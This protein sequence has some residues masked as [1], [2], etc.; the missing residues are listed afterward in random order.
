MG[1][2]MSLRKNIML[3]IEQSSQFLLGQVPGLKRINF[4]ARFFKHNQNLF[5]NTLHSIIASRWA[6]I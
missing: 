6:I 2:I 1:I 4:L 3:F 5:Y